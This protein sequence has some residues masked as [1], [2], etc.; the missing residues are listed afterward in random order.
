MIRRIPHENRDK[1]NFYNEKA[2]LDI[3]GFL[4]GNGFMDWIRGIETDEQAK[5]EEA[6]EWDLLWSDCAFSDRYLC[7]FCECH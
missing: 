1:Y 6:F 7:F 5:Q 2:L 3:L 4:I